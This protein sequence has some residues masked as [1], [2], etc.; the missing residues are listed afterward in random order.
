MQKNRGAVDG[1]QMGLLIEFQVG[2]KL[3]IFGN[4]LPPSNFPPDSGGIEGG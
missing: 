4:Y 3:K 2:D 1:W